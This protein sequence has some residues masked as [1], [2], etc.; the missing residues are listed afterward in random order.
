MILWLCTLTILL[1]TIFAVDRTST[2][3]FSKCRKNAGVTATSVDAV[4]GVTGW[5]K[6]KN[7]ATYREEIANEMCTKHCTVKLK[8][9]LFIAKSG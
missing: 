4:D 8:C 2:Y 1:P 9:A 3:I 7:P 6:T 5:G